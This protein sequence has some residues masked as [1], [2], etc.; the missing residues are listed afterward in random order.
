MSAIPRHW[1]NHSCTVKF[2]ADTKQIYQTELKPAGC[3]TRLKLTFC[4]LIT[5]DVIVARARV[6]GG[7]KLCVGG[8][9]AVCGRRVKAKTRPTP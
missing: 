9:D 3:T 6:R 1:L 2:V 7:R 5:V 8:R 4:L